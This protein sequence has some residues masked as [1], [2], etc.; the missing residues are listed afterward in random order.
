MTRSRLPGQDAPRGG[1][2][3]VEPGAHESDA[4]QAPGRWY[5]SAA[6]PPL[7][8]WKHSSRPITDLLA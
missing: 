7:P 4:L 2:S 3:G 1:A 5:R 8:H 6:W